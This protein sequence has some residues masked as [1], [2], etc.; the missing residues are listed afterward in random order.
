MLKKK[1]ISSLILISCL[2]FGVCV[3][4]AGGGYTDHDG[5]Y[6]GIYKVD[7]PENHT[8]YFNEAGNTVDYETDMYIKFFV[9]DDGIELS[10]KAYNVCV[11]EVYIKGGSGYR[12]YS[13]SG[14]NSAEGLVSP[15]NNGGN[16]PQ[17]SHYGLVDIDICKPQP[18]ETTVAP[19]ETTRP[20]E[21]TIVE[22]TKPSETTVQTE[23]T[24]PT[25]ATQPSETTVQTES[26][27][28]TETTLVPTETTKQKAVPTETTTI[29]Q[30]ESVPIETYGEYV[31]IP[32]TGDRAYTF[33]V[34][35][36]A[37]LVLIG[38]IIIIIKRSDMLS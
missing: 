26:T 12:I 34:I 35:G 24:Q 10:F 9:S 16:T 31:E 15:V 19:T 1:L 4:S 3:V 14:A 13:L 7:P 5:N 30:T 6:N 32:D 2:I 23:S 27:Q 29:I 18:T 20:S 8:V 33:G 17:I 21:T 28:P 36:F 38:L 37:V 11:N 22:T 25:E